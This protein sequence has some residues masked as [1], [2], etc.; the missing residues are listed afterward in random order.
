[1]GQADLIPL[2]RN[3]RVPSPEMIRR[4]DDFFQEIRTRRS[5]RDFSDTPVPRRVIETCLQSAGSAPSGANMQPWKFVVID[6]LSVK[7]AIRAEAEIEER[8]FYERRATPE[9]LEALSVLGTDWKKPFLEKAP[10]L[11]AIFGQTYHLDAIGRKVK[12]YYVQES[13][14]IATGILIAALHQCGLATLTHTPSPMAFLNKILDRPPN[15]RPF[16][17]LVVGY[18]AQDARVPNISRKELSEIA[19]FL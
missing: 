5:V 14:G 15:E 9:W 3:E 7:Q 8:A 11:I 1:M 17:L 18:P 16:L 10:Y 12:H 13:V 4:A 19:V 2:E 6:D